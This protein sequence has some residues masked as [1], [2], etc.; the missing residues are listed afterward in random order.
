MLGVARAMSDLLFF[1]SRKQSA[2]RWLPLDEFGLRRVAVTGSWDDDSGR[3]ALAAWNLEAGLP[4]ARNVGEASHDGG[5]TGIALGAVS[6]AGVQIVTSSDY[7]GVASYRLTPSEDGARVDVLKLWASPGAHSGGAA[8]SVSIFPHD[9]SVVASAGEDGQ[10]ALLSA[11][12]GQKVRAVRAEEDTINR[13]ASTGSCVLATAGRTVRLWD[14]RDAQSVSD[15]TLGAAASAEG[16]YTSVAF[17][18][19]GTLVAAGSSDSVLSV[20]DIR[21]ANARLGHISVPHSTAPLWE[22]AFPPTAARNM[23]LSASADGR[24][25]QWDF[26]SDNFRTKSLRGVRVLADRNLSVNSL[27]AHPTEHEVVCVADDDSIQL[28]S[29]LP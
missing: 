22:L 13:L 6:T 5:V 12:S 2:V 26:A 23:L 4:G 20:W 15:V 7:G 9:P 29:F 25:L 1:T 28:V 14:C 10:L 16:S 11:T 27:D 17:D 18:P 19:T 24:L 21:K 3:S 8:T